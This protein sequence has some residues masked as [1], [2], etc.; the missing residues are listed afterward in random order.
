MFCYTCPC[1]YSTVCDSSERPSRRTK[2]AIAVGHCWNTNA[3]PARCTPRGTA[4]GRRRVLV[5]PTRL[6][7][8]GYIMDAFHREIIGDVSVGDLAAV[9]GPAAVTKFFRDRRRGRE[10]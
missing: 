4:L 6:V 9:V 10:G 7:V 1:T 3:R 8:F 2:N 5:Q